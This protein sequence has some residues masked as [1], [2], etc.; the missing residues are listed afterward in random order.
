MRTFPRPVVVIS[1]C[2][3][4]EPCRY[5][6]EVIPF[7]WRDRLK[8]YVRFVPVCPEVGIGLGIPRDPI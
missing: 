1:K 4:F 7:P 3:E 5:D 6:G 8:P 2:F